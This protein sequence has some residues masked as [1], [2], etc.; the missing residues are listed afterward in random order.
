M[1]AVLNRLFAREELRCNSKN[2]MDCPKY[3]SKLAI[4]S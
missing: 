3:W 1:K 4:V 2:I